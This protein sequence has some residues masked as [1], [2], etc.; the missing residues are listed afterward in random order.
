MEMNFCFIE[1]FNNKL[2]EKLFEQISNLDQLL[3]FLLVMLGFFE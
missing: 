3:F 2:E 1:Q